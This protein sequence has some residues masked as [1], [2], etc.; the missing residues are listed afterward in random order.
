M[1]HSETQTLQAE[2]V[3]V[4]GGARS[5]KSA[6]AEQWARAQAK[7]VLFI[8]TAQALDDEMRERI[9]QHRATRPPEWET[10][11]A[12]RDIPRALAALERAPQLILLDCLT[13]WATNEMLAD[14]AQLEQRLFAQLDL[15]LAWARQRGIV[16][17]LVSNE[18]GWGIV[19][20]NALARHFRD[21]LG[22]VNAYVA[23]AASHV[24]LM[25][26][27]L[28]IEIKN[29]ARVQTREKEEYAIRIGDG[30]YG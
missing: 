1:V 26:A 5:G 14:A 20:E 29:S 23:Q 30:Q 3:F 21:V 16:L 11:E 19:P 6:Y 8:A 15:I 25:V 7:R 22:R 13:L 2:V 4:L 24:I 28:P 9:V 27:G 18:V 17:L 12:P 10:L